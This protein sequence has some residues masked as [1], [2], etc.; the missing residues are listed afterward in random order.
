MVKLNNPLFSLRDTQIKHQML[1]HKL[2]RRVV[3]D[4]KDS[5]FRYAEFVWVVEPTGPRS[6]FLQ[7]T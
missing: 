4:T 2:S 1:I 6:N 5:K 3:A 7:A